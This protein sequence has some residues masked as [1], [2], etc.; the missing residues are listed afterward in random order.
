LFEDGRL[1]LYNLRADVGQKHD[2]ANERP[3]LVRKLHAQI[4]AWRQTVSAPMP[5]RRT[6]RK[7]R[8]VGSTRSEQPNVANHPETVR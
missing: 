6:N 8:A 7:G 2:L 3:D 5:T 4:K 1:E